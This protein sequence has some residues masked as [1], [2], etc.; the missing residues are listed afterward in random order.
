MQ[1]ISMQSTHFSRGNPRTTRLINTLASGT[2]SRSRWAGES[3]KYTKAN[4]VSG[5]PSS[6][7]GVGNPRTIQPIWH[8]ARPQGL[9]GLGNPR[10]TLLKPIWHLARPPVSM[11]WGIPELYKANLASGTPSSSRWAGETR[12]SRKAK[13]SHAVSC[14]SPWRARAGQRPTEKCVGEA[15]LG[16]HG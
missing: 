7:D 3:P 8:L 5:M 11:G 1:S 10:T 6:F 16:T 2:P 13:V 9:D 15:R 12:E 4:L 14:S